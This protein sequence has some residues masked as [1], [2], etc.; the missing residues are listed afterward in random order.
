M[1]LEGIA[2]ADDAAML[3]ETG[4]PTLRKMFVE[5]NSFWTQDLMG[6]NNHKIPAVA[7]VLMMKLTLT[8]RVGHTQ[9]SRRTTP[10]RILRASTSY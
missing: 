2:T 9:S 1:M 10:P 8:I 6:L 3:S 7:T 4:D 5:E